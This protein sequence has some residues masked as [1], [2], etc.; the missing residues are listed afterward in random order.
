[1]DT[2]TQASGMGFWQHAI[3]EQEESGL[4][5]K[6]YCQ[7]IEKSRYQ[8]YYW[9]QRIQDGRQKMMKPVCATGDYIELRPLK[10]STEPIG[11]IEIRIG[12][13]VMN[14]TS[15]TDQEVF[16]KAAA[17]LLEVQN[18]SGVAV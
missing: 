11:F 12:A 10:T 15:D 4:S 13:F 3:R 16:R 17:I 8:F 2:T 7:V 18:E 14:Y 5:V 9:R 1:M 6:D